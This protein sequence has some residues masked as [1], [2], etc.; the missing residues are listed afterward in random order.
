MQKVETETPANLQP[1]EETLTDYKRFLEKT[2][3][4][5]TNKV[6]NSHTSYSLYLQERQTLA[7]EKIAKCLDKSFGQGFL[8]VVTD[9]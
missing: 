1:E 8:D 5:F 6:P 9:Y 7:L 3:E 2:R 4:I